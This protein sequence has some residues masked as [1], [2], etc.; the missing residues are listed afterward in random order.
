M[1]QGDDKTG[2]VGTDAMFVMTPQDVANMPVDRF[3]TY[4][5]IV[6]DFQPHTGGPI[7]NLNHG[8][9]KPNQPPWG[10]D[11]K[12]S[13]HHNVKTSLEQCTQSTKGK[14]HVP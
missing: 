9:Q 13:R 12:N 8:W 7:Q 6:V 1:C 10:V 11:D 5:N 3:A 4:A 2:M 14:I